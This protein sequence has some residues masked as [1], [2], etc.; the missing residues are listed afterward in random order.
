MAA[1]DTRLN[2]LIVAVNYAPEPGGTAPYTAEAAEHLARLGHHVEVVTG[3]PHYPQ[4]E[5]APEYRHRL[6]VTEQRHG[7]TLTRLGLYVPK[8]QSAAKRAAY[9]LSFAAHCLPRTRTRRPDV[10][11]AVVPTLFGAA[12][13]HRIARRAGARL[14]IWVQDS[15]ARA[16]AQSGISGGGA[17]AKLV[18]R[19]E[20]R[21][22]QHADDVVV[23]SPSIAE[24]VAE[25]GVPIDKVHLV[26]NWT[27]ITPATSSRSQM[28]QQL[29]WP[30]DDFIALHAGNMGLKQGLENVVA[31]ARIAGEQR[32]P[33]R[34][35]LMGNGSQRPDLERM[36]AG[37][38]S[39]SFVDPVDDA[40]Y[41]GALAA[42]D[43]L[44]VNER[45]GVLD[46][47]LPSKL[48]TYFA[49]GRPVVA[50]V[51]PRG[52]T[53]AEMGRS[54]GGLVV[55][56]GAPQALLDSVAELLDAPDR[57]RKMGLQGQ[58]YAAANLNA[59]R[60]LGLLADLVERASTTSTTAQPVAAHD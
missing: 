55:Q 57:A 5:V 4:W 60:S 40:S 53:A 32:S 30:E 33:V 22:F 31:A 17:V 54:G 12:A 45:A 7:V 52:G 15:M 35:V 48:T 10:V 2:V 51:D 21:T 50:A 26:P 59:D 16:A 25:S 47:S 20:S 19:L 41:S 9:E 58:T 1:T 39:L 34:F 27:H 3:M 44:L 8:T 43:V 23:I 11:L 46:M 56:N 38:G 49:S 6:T 18:S 42:A 37:L 29:G 24:H 14:V 13:A 28:R 36:A